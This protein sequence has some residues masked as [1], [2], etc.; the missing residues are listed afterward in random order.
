MSSKNLC[1]T[2]LPPALRHKVRFAYESANGRGRVIC[3]PGHHARAGPPRHTSGAGPYGHALLADHEIERAHALTLRGQGI[4]R[5][6]ERL[7][8][9]ETAPEWLA[10]GVLEC[11]AQFLPS[12][13]DRS[14]TSTARTVI[15]CSSDAL[16]SSKPVVVY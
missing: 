5:R 9:L 16:T 1:Q 15:A 10:Q 8:S 7:Q 14:S 6:L 3:A 11:G 13:G 2:R 4:H 12:A